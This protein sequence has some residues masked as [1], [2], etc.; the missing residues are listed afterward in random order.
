MKIKKIIAIALTTLMLV[1]CDL[2]PAGESK[3]T[4]VETEKSKTT[5]KVDSR[6][7]SKKLKQIVSDKLKKAADSIKNEKILF[8]WS[9]K[10]LV[11][12]KKGT[13]EI[14]IEFKD[15]KIIKAIGKSTIIIDNIAHK[16]NYYRNEIIYITEINGKITK[17][18]IKDLKEAGH[19]KVSY[20]VINLIDGLQ[21]DESSDKS[22]VLSGDI[23]DS[24]KIANFFKEVGLIKNND[25]S[26]GT[27]TLNISLDKESGNLYS[28]NYSLKSEDNKTIDEGE[29]KYQKINENTFDIPED[30]KNKAN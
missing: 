1:S 14:D 15:N 13:S 10:G 30:I 17:Y 27:L 23:K 19:S 3:K 25:E 2:K 11:T 26:K 18:N 5:S 12:P 22:Y 8:N 4:K 9:T 24:F 20:A 29:L 21:I 28:I 7:D 6:V 16:S